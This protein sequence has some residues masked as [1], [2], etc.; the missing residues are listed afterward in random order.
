[1]KTRTSGERVNKTTRTASSLI[2]WKDPSTNVLLQRHR[3]L[4]HCQKYESQ[5]EL[6]LEKRKI[7]R[8]LSVTKDVLTGENI[9]T[10]SRWYEVK[11]LVKTGFKTSGVKDVFYNVCS[12]CGKR[13][14]FLRRVEVHDSTRWGPEKTGR[15]VKKTWKR[16]YW[17]LVRTDENVGNVYTVS[18]V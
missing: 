11:V 14:V 13:K 3:L 1:M 15:N 8:C 18:D 9:T 4:L 6:S 10:P 5:K 16:V 2:S 7:Q 12:L 17:L